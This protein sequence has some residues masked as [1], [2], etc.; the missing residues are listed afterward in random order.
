MKKD[1]TVVDRRT[2]KIF[3]IRKVIFEIKISH[4]FNDVLPIYC[5]ALLAVGYLTR[6]ASN[7]RYELRDALLNALSGLFAYLHVSG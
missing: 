5:L 6:F 7:K 2:N 3:N 1:K 4:S